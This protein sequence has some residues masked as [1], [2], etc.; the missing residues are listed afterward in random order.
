MKIRA[1]K[2][3][4]VLPGV[5]K[6]IF[7]ILEKFLPRLKEKTVVA[8]TSKIVAICE[9]SIIPFDEKKKDKII[10]KEADWYL[11]RTSH[12]YNVMLTIK[13]SAMSFSSGV[14]ESNAKGYFVLWPKDPQKSANAIRQYLTKKYKAKNIGVIITDTA[15]VPLRWGQRGVFVLAHS[16]FG[17]LNSYVGKPDIFGRLL[18]MTSA[19]IADALGT[20]AVLVMGEGA[21]Q[22][23]LALIEDVPFVKFQ[24]RD[25][26][27]KELDKLKMFPEDDLYA[28]LLKGVKWR[29]GGV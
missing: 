13:G 4:K 8:V 6:S 25:P 9:G 29:K 19:A 7:E 27:K 15:S 23:P 1:I 22:T 21:E 20:A 17:A 10:I 3:R 16:G 2:T 14:D 12:K 26:N 11:P 28:P 5:D 24:Q 18:K